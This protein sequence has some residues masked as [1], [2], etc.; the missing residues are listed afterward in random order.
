MSL[1]D[2]RAPSQRPPPP[3]HVADPFAGIAAPAL[4]SKFRATDAIIKRLPKE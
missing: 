2:A 1:T 4:L 3:P